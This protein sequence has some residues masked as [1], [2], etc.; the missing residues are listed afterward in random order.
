MSVASILSAEHIEL[1]KG[2]RVGVAAS[3]NNRAALAAV[4]NSTAF[5]SISPGTSFT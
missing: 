2:R 3:A 5:L 4:F 1:A